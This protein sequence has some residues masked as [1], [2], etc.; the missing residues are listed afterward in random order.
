MYDP[1]RVSRG[2]LDCPA[3]RVNRKPAT[4]IVLSNCIAQAVLRGIVLKASKP[5]SLRYEAYR[6]TRLAQALD[7][8]DY[9]LDGPSST[10][11]RVLVGYPLRHQYENTGGVWGFCCVCA[12]TQEH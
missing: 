4:L 10:Q 5:R 11:V 3:E 12:K 1:D 7:C 6:L 8:G 2:V 9:G